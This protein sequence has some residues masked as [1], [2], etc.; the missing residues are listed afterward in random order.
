MWSSDHCPNGPGNVFFRLPAQGQTTQPLE[1]D[2]SFSAAGQ[3][4]SPPQGN[5]SPDTYVV[6]VKAPGMPVARTSFVL[7]QD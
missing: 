5:A 4:Q 7:K 1:W 6:E 2:R 3:C